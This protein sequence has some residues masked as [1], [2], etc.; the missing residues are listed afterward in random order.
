MDLGGLSF[1]LTKKGVR[2]F[3]LK[4]GGRP[5]KSMTLTHN[6]P[7]GVHIKNEQ[8]LTD[9]SQ[10]IHFEITFIKYNL[11]NRFELPSKT[12]EE[13]QDPSSKP[14]REESVMYAGRGWNLFD[15]SHDKCEPPLKVVKNL[16]PPLKSYLPPQISTPPVGVIEASPITD[17]SRNVYVLHFLDF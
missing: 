6:F 14:L 5:K 12:C 11:E 15:F 1:C 2:F 10:I 8:S 3:Q 17:R 16:R 7:G 4:K 9:F 13:F